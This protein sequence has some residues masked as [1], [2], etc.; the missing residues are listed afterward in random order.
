[1]NVHYFRAQLH[2]VSRAFTI[3]E[4]LLHV[5]RRAG[6][7]PPGDPGPCGTGPGLSNT[8]SGNPSTR[9]LAPAACWTPHKPDL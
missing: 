1:M 4:L 3:G 5:S 6:V 7:V 8:G 9:W 2:A